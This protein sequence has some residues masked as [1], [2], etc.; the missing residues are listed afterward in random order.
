MEFKTTT[1]SFEK[2]TG[3]GYQYSGIFPWTGA[4][5][6]QKT[7]MSTQK[8]KCGISLIHPHVVLTAAHCLNDDGIMTVHIG[9]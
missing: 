3:C 2:L 9:K 4:L 1:E 7:S 6:Y 8:Y 5:L